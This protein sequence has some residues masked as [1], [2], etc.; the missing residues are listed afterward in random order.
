M[1]GSCGYRSV[2]APENCAANQERDRD[3]PVT[4]SGGQA[5]HEV[6][7]E[8][9]FSRLH[10]FMAWLAA[11]FLLVVVGDAVVAG[12]S[13]F[14]TIFTVAGWVIWGIFVLEFFARMVIAPSAGTFLRRN[15]WQIVFL[16]LP[17]LALLRFLFAL[18][19]V[20]AGRLLSAAVRGTRSAAAGLRSR[21]ATV[22]AITAIV[23]LMSANL[24]YEFVGIDPYSEALY[25]A[26][27]AAIV[28]EPVGRQDGLAKVLDII[29]SLYSV[30]IFAAVAG[31]AG[32]FFLERD[33]SETD[34][35][36]VRR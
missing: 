12:E 17:F 31:S 25:R 4:A 27:L 33:S 11:L 24:L 28:G 13:P 18:R 2:A 29:L 30:L 5:G 19:V 20:R 9:I 16:V 14:A 32:A 8:T 1:T 23:I 7:A 26:A 3:D 36:I 34:V 6:L 22:G 15:W 21:L 10:P 35:N